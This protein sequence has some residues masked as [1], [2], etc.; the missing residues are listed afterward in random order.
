M[1]LIFTDGQTE[2]QRGQALLSKTTELGSHSPGFKSRAT[3]LSPSQGD[4][5]LPSRAKLEPMKTCLS[6]PAVIRAERGAVSRWVPGPA[7]QLCGRQRLSSDPGAGQEWPS[8]LLEK[9][10]GHG[11][12]KVENTKV[13]NLSGRGEQRVSTQ[14][15]CVSK[16]LPTQYQLVNEGWSMEPTASQP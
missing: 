7:P 6:Q 2:V 9:L 10:A 15:P 1:A 16:P 3:H 4:V 12:Q 14:E 8:R 11:E 13:S 5:L